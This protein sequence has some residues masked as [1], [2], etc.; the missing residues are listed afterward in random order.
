MQTLSRNGKPSIRHYFLIMKQTRS[1]KRKAK[2]E[3]KLGGNLLNSTA[4]SLKANFSEPE[5]V[6]GHFL[7]NE[8]DDAI[9]QVL[10][11]PDITVNEANGKKSDS[12]SNVSLPPISP[13]KSLV[14]EDRKETL[15][16]TT[17]LPRISREQHN[18]STQWLDRQDVSSISWQKALDILDHKTKDTEGKQRRRHNRK[19]S[20]L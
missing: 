10:K 11:L 7:Y 8:A 15:S 17:K 20:K 3:L 16:R 18:G 6:P 19:A 5:E 13:E 2:K 1:R 12:R 14:G 9:Q 4:S